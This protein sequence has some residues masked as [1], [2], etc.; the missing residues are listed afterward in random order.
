MLELRLFSFMVQIHPTF[1]II[2]VFVIELGPIGIA[3]WILAA[4]SSVLIHELGHAF[5]VRWAGGRVHRITLYALGGVTL[6]TEIPGHPVGWVR[7]I[8]IAAAGAGL[9]FVVAGAL[10]GMVRL[11]VFGTQA[12]EFIVSPINVYL[13]NAIAG[14]LWLVF[15]LGAFIWVTFVWGLINWLPIGGLDGSHVLTELL[16]R[17]FPRQGRMAGAVIGLAVAIG[18]GYYL[19]Q[20]GF[21]FAPLIFVLFAMQQFSRVRQR[22]PGPAQTAAP[23]AEPPG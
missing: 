9:G 18:A 13:G 1:L 17:W 21:R 19:Y 12:S 7:K 2:G 4:L 10:L 23:D 5:T 20:R 14:E 8:G 16:E 11:G 6:W 22:P 15:F 3:L